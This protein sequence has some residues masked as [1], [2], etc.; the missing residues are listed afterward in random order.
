L[1]VSCAQAQ[2]SGG[3]STDSAQLRIRQLDVGQGD[4]ALITTPEGRRILVDAGPGADAVANLLRAEGIDTL[5]LVIASHNHADHIGGMARVFAAVVVRA[6]VE[7]GIPHTTATYRRTLAA[8]EREPGLRYLEATARTISVGSVS[9]R[10]LP[11]PRVDASH[12]ANSV[13]AL[14]EYGAFKALYTGDS[15][16]PELETWLAA[17]RVPPVT[18][19]KVAHHGS[20][21]ATTAAWVRATAPAIALIS[22][23]ARNAYGHPAPSVERLWSAAGA[24]IYRTDRHGTIEVRA[25]ADGKYSITQTRGTAR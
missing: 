1:A 13:G 3:G 12:N 17:N 4:A 20:R 6:Y 23:A 14:I 11:P 25:T 8:L 9:V 19:V 10:I 16:I 24:T 22:V 18:L 5:D 15:E 7:N 2:S 21:D